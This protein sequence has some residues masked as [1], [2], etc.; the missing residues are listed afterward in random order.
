[1]CN[2]TTHTRALSIAAIS[3]LPACAVS[4]SLSGTEVDVVDTVD[5]GLQLGNGIRVNGSANNGIRVNGI[6][7]NGIRVNGIRVNG[8][9]VNGIDLDD[10]DIDGT[11]LSEAEKDEFKQV[12]YRYMVECALSPGQT[13]TLYDTTAGTSVS[14]EGALGLA[15]SWYTGPLDIDGQERVSACMAARAN[16]SEQTVQISL[17]GSGIAVTALESDTFGTHEGI[18]WG[19]LFD[20]QSP[21]LF[22]CMVDGGG[23]SGRVCAQSGDCGFTLLGDCAQVCT[24]DDVTQS[25]ASC[26]PGDDDN[27][28]EVW[29]NLSNRLVF[30][31]HNAARRQSDGT[32]VGWGFNDTGQLTID[33]LQGTTFATPLN[34]TL[35]G[36]DNAELLINEHGCS[37]KQSGD[38]YCW[39][40][41]RRGE[42][43]NGQNSDFELDPL[44]V[45]TDAAQVIVGRQHTCALKT[46]GSVWCWGSNSE[47]Q[48]GVNDKKLIASHIPVP[49]PT[50]ASGVVRLS[51]STDSMHTCA[52]KSDGSVWCW[53][54]GTNGQ[55]GNGGKSNKVAPV[56][57]D[58]DEDRNDFG[59]ITDICASRFLTCAR[60]TD[61]TAWCWG[62]DHTFESSRPR[63]YPLSDPANPD[64]AVSPGGLT[65]GRKVACVVATDST[66]WCMGKNQAGQLGYDDGTSES[67]VM[68]RVPGLSSVSFVNAGQY[69]VCAIQMDGTMV[70]W[71]TDPGDAAEPQRPRI[72]SPQLSST[73]T[74]IMN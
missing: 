54:R 43:G 73:P 60:K 70:C 33:P 53:G 1:M 38:V 45:F 22:A 11:A 47:G 42:V 12:V 24:Y 3:V 37:R 6:R 52:A 21:E 13:A 28:V 56:E 65:C 50:L 14:Y 4:P 7:V 40:E 57:V 39:G 32:A 23:L 34:L 8:I 35:L 61:G 48:L 19:N 68:R 9:R 31:R 41:N 71:G 30:G 55:L 20:E 72:F 62:G 69:Y 66:V 29:L 16:A 10:I 5:V 63:H 49:I 51:T 36:N 67:N 27:L 2:W 74:V 17:R 46:D 26:G 25:Y 15:S 58:Q 44:F 18:F 64:L 59:D